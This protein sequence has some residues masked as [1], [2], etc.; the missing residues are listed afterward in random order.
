MKICSECQSEYNDDVEFC[1]RDGMKLR[2]AMAQSVASTPRS[3]WSRSMDSNKAL[4]LPSPKP[5]SPLR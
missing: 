5:S 1:A 2:A 3:I 4:K